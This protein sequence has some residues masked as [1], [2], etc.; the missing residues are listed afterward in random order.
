MWLKSMSRQLWGAHQS[1]SMVNIIRGTVATQTQPGQISIFASGIAAGSSSAWALS[2]PVILLASGQSV[3]G[4]FAV[5]RSAPVPLVTYVT[6]ALGR[7][8]IV[9]GGPLLSGMVAITT[10]PGRIELWLGKLKAPVP[11]LL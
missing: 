10:E 2:G 3:G 9:D 8:S 1:S 4:G 7:S 6:S 11:P 5:G